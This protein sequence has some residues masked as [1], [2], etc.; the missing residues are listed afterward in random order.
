MLPQQA[1]AR[2]LELLDKAIS[3]DPGEGYA[4]ALRGF[5]L[6]QMRQYENALAEAEKALALDPNQLGVLNEAAS[7]LARVGKPEE[8]VP[9]IR[10]SVSP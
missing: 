8:A 1:T 10:K 2:A 4:Y 6:M 7:I 9:L 5:I 3:L